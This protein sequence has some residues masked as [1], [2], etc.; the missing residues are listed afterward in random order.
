MVS[1]SLGNLHARVS[2]G[3]LHARVVCIVC[4]MKQRQASVSAVLWLLYAAGSS[5]C[6]E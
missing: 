6:E 2:L 5:M 1:A 4:C 3:N